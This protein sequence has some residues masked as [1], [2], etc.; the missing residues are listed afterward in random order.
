VLK[1]CKAES[2]RNPWKILH[3]REGI[4][5]LPK[6]LNKDL[7]EYY[8]DLPKVKYDH[9]AGYYDYQN[10]APHFGDVVLAAAE[11]VKQATA[12]NNPRKTQQREVPPPDIVDLFNLIPV[13]EETG[14]AMV[15]D[16]FE[17]RARLV[18]EKLKETVVDWSKYG[19]YSFGS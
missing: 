5:S 8:A 13:P 19:F 4:N 14:E 10:E 7:D 16:D 2:C 6:A 1:S 3:D 18:P 12:V 9:C 17:S 11:T 15:D